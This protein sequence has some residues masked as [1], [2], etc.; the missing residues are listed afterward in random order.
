MTRY[1]CLV[2]TDTGTDWR[3]VEALSET[4]VIQTLMSE[5][6]TPL[7]IRSGHASLIER[8]NQPVHLSFGISAAERAMVM[9]QLA[10][11]VRSGLAVD[12]ALDLLGTQERKVALRNLLKRLFARLRSGG[13]LGAGFTDE[14]GFPPYVAGLIRA[15]EQAGHLGEALTQAAERLRYTA[16]LRSQ[17]ITALSYPAV[18]LVSTLLALITVLTVVIP[19]FAPIFS[20]EEQRL[21]VL[22]QA[23]LWLSGMSIDHGLAALGVMLG[24]A[25]ATMLW[26]HSSSGRDWFH[27]IRPKLPGVA[28]LDQLRAGQLMG[29][30]ALLIANGVTVVEALSLARRS[31]A[32]R[33]WRDA[34]WHAERQLREGARLSQA[35][36]SQKL[37][38]A[39]A[40]RLAE[41]GE[42][43]GKLPE[44]LKQASMLLEQS[45][46]SRIDRLVSLANPI[47]II[48]LGGAIALLVAGVMLGIFSL[49]DFAG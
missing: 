36:G 46:R 2:A 18:V 37:M 10:L 25:L 47:A 23:V 24:I 22:T 35:L 41:V 39:I 27:R 49:G 3:M 9:E 11:L 13:S 42:R 5:G 44:T 28:L 34:L 33:E 19:Q 8:L 21:P 4:D 12:R 32:G 17:L 20:G 40:A 26:L 45:A 31:A 29:V 15:A 48:L 6:V 1:H 43:S 30:L 38:P 14:P 16:S 7:Q